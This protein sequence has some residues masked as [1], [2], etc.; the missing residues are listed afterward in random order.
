MVQNFCTDEGV[1]E[2]SDRTV[3]FLKI[4]FYIKRLRKTLLISTCV[5][6]NLY[7]YLLTL[8]L[9]RTHELS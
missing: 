7:I 5:F 1:S 8:Y 9:T 4:V 2:L 3:S 6:I